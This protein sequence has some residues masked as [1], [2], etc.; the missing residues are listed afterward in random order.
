[1]F[2]WHVIIFWR[3]LNDKC[4]FFLHF[5]HS[6]FGTHSGIDG[7]LFMPF[8]LQVPRPITVLTS[9]GFVKIRW[10][11]LFCCLWR[12]F[13]WFL[14][15]ADSDTFFTKSV[16]SSEKVHSFLIRRIEFI[17]YLYLRYRRWI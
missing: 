16:R 1:M 6:A 10:W 5:L 13:H 17:L 3:Q 15:V 9:Q 4:P 14:G 7:G 11:K 2:N 12:Y 8:C